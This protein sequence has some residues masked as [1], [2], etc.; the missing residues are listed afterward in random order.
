MC[1]ATPH[2]YVYMLFLLPLSLSPF[3]SRQDATA[4]PAAV[5]LPPYQ[6]EIAALPADI[7]V[8][9]TPY[10]PPETDDDLGPMYR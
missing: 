9:L 10:A 2:H 1:T 4:I 8:A 5:P 6:P 7:I 3:L